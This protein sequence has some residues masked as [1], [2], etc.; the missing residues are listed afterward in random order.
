MA[1]LEWFQADATE[2]SV[3]VTVWSDTNGTVT[4]TAGNFS[5]SV[6]VN[7][8][9]RF[10]VNKVDVT[11]LSGRTGVT[12]F[13][14]AG[15]TQTGNLRPLPSA[16][17]TWY[18]GFVSC[19]QSASPNY[20]PYS[21]MEQYDVRMMW[22][23]DDMPYSDSTQQNNTRW[24]ATAAVG[25]YNG[26]AA[27]GA[28][29]YFNTYPYMMSMFGMRDMMQ[30]CPTIFT[31]G[32]HTVGDNW[33]HAGDHAGGSTNFSP[34]L[35]TQADIDDV[36]SMAM[37]AYDAFTYGNPPA[38]T[39]SEAADYKPSSAAASASNYP[40]RYFRKTVG[41]VEF[42]AP[43]TM[44]HKCAVSKMDP[45]TLIDADADAKTMAGLPQFNWLKN[46]IPASVADFKLIMTPAA[47]YNIPTASQG[48]WINYLTER[49][50]ISGYLGAN[51][52]GLL[53]CTGDTHAPIVSFGD[54][55]HVCACPAGQ[56]VIGNGTGY[57]ADD[58]P[59][60]NIWRPSGP[61]SPSL[62][63]MRNTVGL[64]KITPTYIQPMILATDGDVLYRGGKIY[65]GSNTPTAD[66]GTIGVT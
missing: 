58:G 44:S 2:T 43:D 46:R 9:T 22:F 18:L 63:Q 34:A 35:A 65:A 15:I 6:S 24:Q 5:E 38:T 64:V 16:G 10:G 59:A 21:V 33:D 14:S 3:V 56:G 53:A 41:N 66:A 12:V 45:A 13:H 57:W 27:G 20:W 36:W 51:A 32:D 40:A 17:D 28:Q 47:F 1:R 39:D 23:Q 62:D 48:D 4:V 31:F 25:G 55:L 50:H 61:A 11:G 52:T 54:F 42:F 7:T 8:A 26:W 19:I 60:S 29:D 49:D 37:E 30:F